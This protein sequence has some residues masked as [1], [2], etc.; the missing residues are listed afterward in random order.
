MKSQS[1]FTRTGSSSQGSSTSLLPTILKLAVRGSLKTRT[2]LFTIALFIAINVGVHAMA[3]SYELEA[4]NL[5][6]L[7]VY[8]GQQYVAVSE[9]P[10]ANAVK[11]QVSPIK[12]NG[13][14]VLLISPEN[15]TE[16][17]KVSGGSL[18]GK[19]PIASDEVAVGEALRNL[20]T[21]NRLVIDG[22][23]FKV[24]G[25]LQS[26]GLLTYSV[27]SATNV[28]P[29]P[30][31]FYASLS[32]D[33]RLEVSAPAAEQTARSVF[34]EALAIMSVV[35]YALYGALGLS[36]LFQGYNSLIEAEV[37]LETLA[38]VG[39]PVKMVNISMFVYAFIVSAVGV[40]LGFALGIFI[41][42][43][44]SSLASILFR[45][46][47][48]KP[49]INAYVGLDLILGFSASLLALTT[50]L[51]GGYSRQVASL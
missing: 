51:L 30:Q 26:D 40:V 44:A 32:K 34:S 24:T 3:S 16:F 5:I 46:P 33:S 8:T 43:L 7:S 18:S 29:N 28:V 17:L 42:G 50:G 12:I 25:F 1:A 22:R 2:I 4:I 10:L 37:V 27:V 31:T 21:N 47:H 11:I 13:R 49:F 38:S 19:A 6:S 14:T 15:F 48:L 9:K 45:L 23:A 41:P 39:A 36:C 35:G 20:V